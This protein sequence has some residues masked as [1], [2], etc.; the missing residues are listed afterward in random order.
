[1]SAKPNQAAALTLPSTQPLPS[2]VWSSQGPLAFFQAKTLSHAWHQDEAQLAL[3]Q[4]LEI[5]WQGLLTSP[6]KPLGSSQNLWEKLRGKANL[7]RRAIHPYQGQGGGQGFYIYGKAGRGKT[8]I[9]D[10]L[11]EASQSIGV[12][13]HHFHEFMQSVHIWLKDWRERKPQQQDPLHYYATSLANST[14]LICLDELFI[15]DIA[16]AMLV[17]RLF[18]A[19]L[20]A[21]VSVVMTS[22][23]APTELYQD[24]L[25]RQ[26]FIPFISLIEERLAV[27]KLEAAMD[28]R[29]LSQE[30]AHSY[31][32]PP[33]PADWAAKRFSS[34][35]EGMASP[36]LTLTIYQRPWLI[37]RWGTGAL[38]RC[39]WFNF[40]TLCAEN[41]GSAD[42]LALAEA[43]DGLILEGVPIISTAHREAGK[44]FITLI[45]LWYEKHRW[46]ICEAA[47]LPDELC[48]NAQLSFAFQRTASRLI[49][50]QKTSYWQKKGNEH[51]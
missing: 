51:D 10:C 22:N 6:A 4:R 50:M 42:Y 1:M 25:Q 31:L 28:Y 15:D 37:E 7:K 19:L 45:D 36:P 34:L 3:L 49:E 20:E 43:F 47:A 33:I 24:G 39:V 29:R 46:L 41:L 26:Q 18:T 11:V 40:P 12:R 17:G 38:G 35:T 21:G 16:D 14:R 8:L 27:V 44:R 30:A 9:M 23:L 32:I 2:R 5:F 48:H 13:R